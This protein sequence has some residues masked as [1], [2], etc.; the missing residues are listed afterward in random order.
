LREIRVK[1]PEFV[2]RAGVWILLLYRRLHYGYS[3]RKIPLTQGKF[4]IVDEKDYKELNKHKWSASKIKTCYYATRREWTKKIQ[5][6]REIKMH[7]QVLNAPDDKFVDHINHNGLDN[8]RVNLRIVTAW[9]NNLNKRKQKKQSSSRY[10]GVSIKKG[11][12][13]WISTIHYK[14]SQIYIGRFDDEEAAARAYDEKA[15]ELFGEYACLNFP[16]DSST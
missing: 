1:I 4:A 16:S 7:R 15:K 8:R 9:Q 11:T 5:K 6:Y 2:Y 13:K 14:G 3:F 10:K 12:G